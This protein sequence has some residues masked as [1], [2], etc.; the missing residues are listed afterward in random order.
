MDDQLRIENQLCFSIYALSKEF[1]KLYNLFLK[2]MNV[3]YPQYLVLL[4]LWEKNKL[5]VKQLGE[6]LLLDS[7]TLTPLLKRMEDAD[8]VK[9]ERSKEDERKVLVSLTSKGMEMREKAEKIPV[10]LAEKLGLSPEQFQ[11]KLDENREL[12]SKILEVAES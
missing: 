11:K 3:T 8:I 4:V 9:R 5:T 10:C 7:G 2:D 1:T 12:L 6:N